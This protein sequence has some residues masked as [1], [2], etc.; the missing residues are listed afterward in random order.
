MCAAGGAATCRGMRGMGLCTSTEE[1]GL[2]KPPVLL[3][4][5]TDG[6]CAGVR[7]GGSALGDRVRRAERRSARSCTSSR[8]LGTLAQLGRLAAAPFAGLETAGGRLGCFAGGCGSD[9]KRDLPDAATEAS[10]EATRQP[11]FARRCASRSADSV[12]RAWVG[13]ALKSKKR[14][15]G[16]ATTIPLCCGRGCM[17]ARLQAPLATAESAIAAEHSQQMRSQTRR[18]LR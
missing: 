5:A 11:R 7:T 16:L 1:A 4:E 3:A 8:G 6:T 2:R 14:Q 18:D 17:A 9:R 10:R 13:A 15:Q 12:A